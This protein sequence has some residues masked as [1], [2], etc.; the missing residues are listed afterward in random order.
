M[1]FIQLARLYANMSLINPV[2]KGA[3]EILILLKDGTL[4]AGEIGQHFDMTGAAISY[5]LNQLKKAD[6][7]YE[8]NKRISFSMK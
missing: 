4:S 8:K 5:H 7:I 6:L 3:R 1:N 2:S